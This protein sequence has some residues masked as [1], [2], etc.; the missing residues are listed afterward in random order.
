VYVEY[1][2]SAREYYRT[3]GDPAERVNVYGR[4]RASERARLHAR[5]VALA[6]CHGA[7]AS[8]RAG[9]GR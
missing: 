8:W 7:S 9:G 1:R 4:L 2:G 5:L 3:D 6:G